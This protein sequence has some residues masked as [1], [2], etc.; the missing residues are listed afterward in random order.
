LIQHSELKELVCDFDF[1]KQQAELT[2]SRLL[3]WNL[4]VKEMISL[5]RKRLKIFQTENG[6]FSVCLQ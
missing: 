1:S 5:L 3:Q 6:E 2:G 4:L